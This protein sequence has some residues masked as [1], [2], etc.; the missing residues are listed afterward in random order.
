MKAHPRPSL[1]VV[2]LASERLA[3]NK[4]KIM[5]V[6]L[7]RVCSAIP[8][9]K[10]QGGAQ[11]RDSIPKFLDRLIQS[12]SPKYMRLISIEE[13][14]DISQDHGEQRS[15]LEEYSLYEVLSEYRILRE[16]IV[17]TLEEDGPISSIE[18]DIILSA[19]E[20]GMAEAGA[21][22]MALVNS[23]TKIENERFRLVVESVKEHAIL[24][25]SSEGQI[26]DWNSGAENIFQYKKEEILG[27]DARILFV[28]EDLM[29]RAPEKEMEHAIR[30]GKA[31]DQRWH[32]RKDGTRFFASGI[33]NPI[34]NDQDRVF[35]FVKV[36][37]DQ[38]E[39]RKIQ[40]DL[41]EQK[42]KFQTIFN[43]APDTIILAD[44]NRRI[45]ACNPAVT[46][47]FG[48]L[49]EELVGKTTSIFY[50]DSK[51]YEEQGRLHYRTHTKAQ[52]FQTYLA[53]YR[54]KNC[55]TF[56]SETTAA[57]L[58][59]S[60]DEVTGY[61]ALFR[62]V[63]ERIRAESEREM[64]LNREKEAHRDAEL[65]RQ[66]LY[67]FFMQAPVP[68]VVLLGQEHR[69]AIANPPYE[70]LVRR[71]VIGK[72]ALEAFSR[73]EIGHF[74]PLLDNVF[75]TG[76]PYNGKELPLNIHDE[77]GAIQDHWINIGFYPYRDIQGQIR[78]ILSV[79]QEVTEQVEARKRVEQAIEKLE[80]ERDLRERFVAT[81]SHDLRTPLTAAKMGSQILMQHS[82]KDPENF[83][84]VAL[85]ILENLDRA[86]QMIRDLLDANRIKAG[87]KLPIE[88]SNIDIQEL[89]VETIE[90]LATIHGN[91]FIL[92]VP[93]SIQGYWSDSGI[94]RILENL[95]INGIKY[96]AP[97]RPITISIFRRNQN[98]ELCVHNDG[99]P[100]PAR[101]HKSLFEPF[102]R[103]TSAQKGG[104][105][106]WGLGL[107]L[108]RGITEAHGGSVEVESSY[109]HGT[110][111][112][113]VFP[114][115]SRPFV[116]KDR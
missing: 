52:G 15:M 17:S 94:R 11:L 90:E 110:T 115:D 58:R 107:T 38:T 7:D 33:M 2:P 78:G 23:K 83:S 32:I 98:V 105:K 24:R 73:E 41:A 104:Q 40:N 28:P 102:Q 61:L 45:V 54:K 21:H 42:N 14:N 43:F 112:K 37:R 26:L 1:K 87:E 44:M 18:R 56:I 82:G 6:W 69:F 29:Q 75:T 85:K 108:V 64:L 36:L 49:P 74:L 30:T 67:E 48:Y 50:T 19:I 76:V 27:R 20:Q 96:G 55:E 39:Q 114:V 53:R 70:R 93:E 113:V 77:G 10:K 59:N 46:R 63:T 25:M 22:F 103:T 116:N 97:D 71:K 57:I 47:T 81:L 5:G 86:D 62:D 8:A 34:K 68:L 65:A 89:A 16:V 106:G 72:T 91:R 109:E 3:A 12:L 4:E 66:E 9:A 80:A 111:F 100:I 51:E 92:E 31:E 79:A 35:G 88:I 13:L 60:N 95:C 99:E 84:K 101:D